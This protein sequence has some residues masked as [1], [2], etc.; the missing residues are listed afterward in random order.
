MKAYCPKCGSS[1]VSMRHHDSWSTC[2]PFSRTR[3]SGEHI[4]RTC[5]RWQYE[6]SEAPLD[7]S[8]EAMP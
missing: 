5:E 4:H 8:R 6:W 1:K 2:S 7:A 3:F